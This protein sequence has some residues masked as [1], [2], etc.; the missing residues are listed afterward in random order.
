MDPTLVWLAHQP[1]VISALRLGVQ[2]VV[3]FVVG[4]VV[5]HAALTLASGPL[6]P[7]DTRIFFASDLRSGRAR[8]REVVALWPLAV[9]GPADS[10]RI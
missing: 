2:S 5:I 1:F 3:G 10:N 7:E 6:V 4:L 9:T 8:L